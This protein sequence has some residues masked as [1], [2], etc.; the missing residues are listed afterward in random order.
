[1]YDFE[2]SVA[3]YCR[4][5]P[6]DF[7]TAQGS[8]L[9]DADGRAYLDFLAGCGSLNYGHN[10]PRLSEA[11]VD[12]IQS[13][14]P[15]MSLDLHTGAKQR[16]CETFR[17][18]I[19]TP[20]GMDYRMMFTGP[21]GTNAVEAA[22]KIARK[23]TGRRTVLSFTNGFHGCTLGALALTGSGH[24]RGSGNPITDGVTRLPYEGYRGLGIDSADYIEAL[25]DDPSGGLDAPA[26]F[27]LEVI[28]GEGGLNAATGRWLRRIES[29]ARKHGALLIV[30]DIQA[31]CGRS[32]SFFSFE[33]MSVTPDMIL[34]AKSLS[35]YGLPMAMVLLKP[36]IDVLSPGEHNGT[37]RGNC[38]GFVTGARALELFW[39]DGAFQQDL[40]GKI[41]LLTAD[42]TRIAQDYGLTCKGRGFM[43]GLAFADPEDALATRARCYDAGLIVE[44]CGPHD[45]VLKLL[46]PLT[47]S[48]EEITSACRIIAGA[49]QQ[50]L[51]TQID[52]VA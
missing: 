48:A 5:F 28:Q 39:R 44:C 23:A 17:D 38:H 29:I 4:A 16:F 21:T 34:L 52:E 45:E 42:L 27:V 1:M 14:G 50:T 32:G 37:F 40:S 22:I 41:A 33:E 7:A 18:V 8:T 20:R 6:A 15:A 9:T 13:G 35:G 49:V 24:H 46:P 10:D 19:L 51:N 11:L 26:A 36:E 30:D 43:Q 31:G 12:Y 25:L 3:T 2:S 47:A